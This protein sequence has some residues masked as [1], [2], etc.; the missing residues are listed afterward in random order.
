[1]RYLVADLRRR[2]HYFAGG[3]ALIF[4]LSG[5]R[6]Y[7]LRFVD[8]FFCRDLVGWSSREIREF[9]GD[10]CLSEKLYRGERI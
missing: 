8:K 2:R 10:E 5:D 1:M 4:S 9:D 6:F 3:S 7:G